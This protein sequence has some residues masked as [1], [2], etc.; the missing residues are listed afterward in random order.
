MNRLTLSNITN[1]GSSICWKVLTAKKKGCPETGAA[2]QLKM[3]I[4]WF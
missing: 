2:L 4:T 1:A 3:D